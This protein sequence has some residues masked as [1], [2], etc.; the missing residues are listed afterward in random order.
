M[1]FSNRSVSTSMWVHILKIKFCL[2]YSEL[3]RSQFQVHDVL[4][5][6]SKSQI[7]R[8]SFAGRPIPPQLVNVA[9]D[10]KILCHHSRCQIQLV[11]TGV[12][13]NVSQVLNSRSES[14]PFPC[15]F[16]LFVW[17]THTQTH[18]HTHTHIKNYQIR[19]SRFDSRRSVQT[20]TCGTNVIGIVIV[21]VNGIF[22]I[23][24]LHDHRSISHYKYLTT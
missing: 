18:T 23:S 17:V 4:N 19:W 12:P 21:W 11:E 13:P 24:A 2:L 14:S 16:N 6:F 8:M 5:I 7:L 22:K 9:Y 10:I 1:I 20:V 15:N 3:L